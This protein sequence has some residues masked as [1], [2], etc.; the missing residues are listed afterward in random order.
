MMNILENRFG[1]GLTLWLVFGLAGCVSLKPFPNAFRAG[2]TITLSIGSLDG[3]TKN[4]ITVTYYDDL[5]TSRVNPIDLTSSI[6]TVFKI[7]PDKTSAA[8]NEVSTSG[9]V[10]ATLPSWSGHGPWLTVVSLDLPNSSVLSPGTGN[11]IVTPG[12]GVTAPNV[13]TR[14]EDIEIPVE[15]LPGDGARD[16]L[17]Y[18]RETYSLPANGNTGKLK[19]LPQVVVKPFDQT[20]Q[21]GGAAAPVAAAEYVLNVPITD[22]SSVPDSA[23]RVF[24]DDR[25][26]DALAQIQLSWARSGDNLRVIVLSPTGL[27]NTDLVRF[28]VILAPPGSYTF[29]GSPSLVSAAYYG[30]DGA[31]ATGIDPEVVLLYQ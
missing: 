25:P 28:S 15:I 14:V 26:G 2:D 24:W 6:R 1:F 31:P 19:P 13:A 29:A 10:L 18:Y 23:V 27:L 4:N 8:W 7:Y 17:A 16:A 22:S 5:D 9:A 11:I 21:Y 3:A 20:G 30:I 12:A